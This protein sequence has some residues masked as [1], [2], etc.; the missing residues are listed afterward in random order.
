GEGILDLAER[1]EEGMQSLERRAAGEDAR[2]EGVVRIA[3]S[4]SFAE[5]YLL[6]RLG[7]LRERHPSILVEVR[8]GPSFVALSRREADLAIRLRPKGS[9]PAQEN[10]VCRKLVEMGFAFHASRE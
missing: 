9:P 8:T 10:V 4:D 7:K 2:V 5:H 3:T 6:P 1:V